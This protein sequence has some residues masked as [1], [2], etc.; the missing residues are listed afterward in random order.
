[1]ICRK[2]G[3]SDRNACFSPT[4]GACWW[5]EEGLC[6]HCKNKVADAVQ[7]TDHPDT[8]IELE[9]DYPLIPMKD[10]TP[11]ARTIAV[12]WSAVMEHPSIQNKHKLASD[13][14]N[15]ARRYHEKK[16]KEK[17]ASK[18]EAEAILI[19]YN[20]VFKRKISLTSY[21]QR[22]ICGRIKE[23]RKLKPPI[24]LE[25]FRA[26]FEHKKEKWTGTDMEKYLD[27]ET[28]VAQKHFFKYLDQARADK[29]FI[30]R[31]KNQYGTGKSKANSGTGDEPAHTILRQ[32]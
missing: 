2:C 12:A 31:F 32:D 29:E 17:E 16:T 13:I 22:A 11:E 8:V 4:L 9:T 3:C 26:V 15:Y 20:E 30:H 1:M 19:L 14:M 23:G 10:I 7:P 21:R 5:V 6:S 24:G 28:L 18:A 27:I 25:Q